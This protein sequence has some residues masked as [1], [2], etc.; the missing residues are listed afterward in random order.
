MCGPFVWSV[1][2]VRVCGPCVCG[3]CVW[4][5]CVVRVCG[6][7]VWSVC[8]VRVCG[9]RAWFVCVVRACG[10]K[11]RKGFGFGRP[12]CGGLPRLLLASVAPSVICPVHCSGGCSIC[13]P[14]VSRV[15]I[16]TIIKLSSSVASEASYAAKGNSGFA[17]SGLNPLKGLRLT[18][19]SCPNTI[20]RKVKYEAAQNDAKT[21]GVIELFWRKKGPKKGPK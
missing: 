13:I 21:E 16:N 9:P 10:G 15:A 3:P 5:A 18:V 11:R 6:P 12:S 7:C 20:L 1:C 8:V 17:K 4:S 2:V 19:S 14:G